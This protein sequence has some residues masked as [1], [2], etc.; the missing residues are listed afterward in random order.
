MFK[1]TVKKIMK[2]LIN[3]IMDFFTECSETRNSKRYQWVDYEIIYHEW[4]K[5]RVLLP[6]LII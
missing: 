2:K 4:S 5:Y 3:F 1:K 6:V